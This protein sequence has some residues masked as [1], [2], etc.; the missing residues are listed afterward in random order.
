[1]LH[2]RG[3][4]DVYPT[5]LSDVYPV[6]ALTATPQ[7]GEL[8][9]G[10][11]I[12]N[13]INVVKDVGKAT[14]GAA[15]GVGKGIVKAGEATVKI[16]GKVVDLAILPFDA[17]VKLSV[18][19]ANMM[20]NMPPALQ[21]STAMAAGAAAGKPMSPQEAQQFNRMFCSLA[22]Q[23]KSGGI[24]SAKDL[25]NFKKMLPIATKIGMEAGNM[26]MRQSMQGMSAGL[27]Q[28]MAAGGASPAERAAAQQM[29]GFAEL[30]ALLDQSAKELANVDTP[31][32]AFNKGVKAGR[33]FFSRTARKALQNVAA[34]G[35][36]NVTARKVAETISPP[37]SP[38]A[39]GMPPPPAPPPSPKVQEKAQ[40][41]AL[42]T[43]VNVLKK[44]GNLA[45]IEGILENLAA[46]GQVQLVAKFRATGKFSGAPV[47]PR[48]KY[49]LLLA[50]SGAGLVTGSVLAYRASRA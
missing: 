20:C 19:L 39:P 43:M 13:P 6:T 29:T 16:G 40:A 46:G 7:A 12:P 36:A 31:K 35:V 10:F 48:G 42:Q 45:A 21:V 50:L 30:D 22:R 24:K 8:G 25:A 3:L 11:K 14:V 26:A 37:P 28:Q 34:Q 44:Q 49:G 41:A 4:E 9:F 15:K 18:K 33:G 2:A 1:M 27:Q 32:Q 23:M 5:T 47:S 38:P 17:M